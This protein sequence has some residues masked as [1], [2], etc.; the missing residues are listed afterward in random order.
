MKQYDGSFVDRHKLLDRPVI[1]LL[2]FFRK[3]ASWQ[4][5]VLSVGSY[6]FTASAF[7]IATVRACAFLQVSL[8]VWAFAHF[9][10]QPLPEQYCSNNYLEAH[11]MR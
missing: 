10:Q 11:W 1:S 4:L 8:Q 3:T 5:T 9:Q 6:A 7:Q 2:Y